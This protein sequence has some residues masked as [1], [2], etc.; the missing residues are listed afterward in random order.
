[1]VESIVDRVQIVHAAHHIAATETPTDEAMIVMI[2]AAAQDHAQKTTI[3]IDREI[4]H[5]HE[6][7][8]IKEGILFNFILLKNESKLVINF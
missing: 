3:E 7:I 5:I 6:T 1:V 8:N 4:G 2:A